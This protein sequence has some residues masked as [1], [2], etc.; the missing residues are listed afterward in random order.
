MSANSKIEWTDHTFNPWW[1]CVKVSEACTNC[2][3]EDFGKRFGVAWGPGE[4]RK[5]FGEDHWKEPLRWDRAARKAGARRRVFCASMA[6]VFEVLPPGHPDTAAW[7][8]AAYRLG[9]TIRATPNLTWLLLTKRPENISSMPGDAVWYESMDENMNPEP[10]WPS[11][12]WLGVTVENQGAADLRVPELLRLKKRFGI[13]ATFVSCEPLLESLHLAPW[14]SPPATA[15]HAPTIDWVIAGGESGGKARPSHPD[16]FRQLRDQCQ[17][18]GVAF[19]FKQWGE[20]A[21]V[22]SM[23]G[24]PPG[25]ES[26]PME[27]MTKAENL[28]NLY[29][30]GDE[31]VFIPSKRTTAKGGAMMVRCGKKAAG[32]LLDGREWNEMPGR[33]AEGKAA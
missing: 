11:N 5:F 4:R 20:W 13:P 6:D 8:R 28:K 25:L 17:R 22:G 12:A 26:V 33:P 24:I 23:G 3:A 32:R 9:E 14:L 21:P 30:D 19:F 1:G 15:P 27:C 18:A 31:S 29:P 16:W 2:Y 7:W 10:W